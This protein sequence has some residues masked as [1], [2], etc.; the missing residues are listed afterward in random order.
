MCLLY[1]ICKDYWPFAV[2]EG[3]EFKRLIK[4]LAPSYKIPSV[5]TLKNTLDNKYEVTKAILKSCLL[6]APHVIIT[7]DPWTE[8]MNEKSFLGV[9]VHYLKDISLKSHCL[10]VAELKE[11][12]TAQYLSDIIQKIL[13]D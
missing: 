13:S 1:F 9:T 10:A 3:E 8:T 12:H 6:A 11:R 4:E 7:F 2:V 5:T